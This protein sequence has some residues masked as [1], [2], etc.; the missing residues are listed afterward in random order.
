M[1]IPIK[2]DCAF[3]QGTSDIDGFAKRGEM[4]QNPEKTHFI[5]SHQAI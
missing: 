4:V 1:I 2:L 3:D 5:V